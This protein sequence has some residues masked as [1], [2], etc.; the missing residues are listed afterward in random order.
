MDNLVKLENGGTSLTTK[1]NWATKLWKEKDK[2]DYVY[3]EWKKP[4][5]KDNQLCDSNQMTFWQNHGASQKNKRNAMTSQR[6][7]LS[8][9]IMMSTSH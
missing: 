5:W 8:Y 6:R 4:I 3:Y 7:S 1:K 9:M 2:N